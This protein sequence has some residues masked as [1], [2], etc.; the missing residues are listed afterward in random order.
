VRSNAIAYYYP[1]GL[2]TNLDGKEVVGSAA[3]LALMAYVKN[4]NMAEVW[5][6]PMGPERGV[7]STVSN[8]GYVSG[9]LGTPTT[10]V[11]LALNKGQCDSLYKVGTDINPIV[12][13][14]DAGIQ[15]NGQ[16]TSAT[17]SSALDRVNVQRL[18]MKMIRDLKRYTRI[19]VGKRNSTTNRKNLRADITAYC[20]DLVTRDAL[21]DFAVYCDT[22]N[23]TATTIDR[24]ELHAKVAFKPTKT[25]EFVYIDLVPVNT[26]DSLK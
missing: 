12:Y 25:V 11:P 15:V 1:A 5:D 8:V 13:F 18:I 7:L 4:D 17:V 22:T 19:Y 2:V 23:N 21:Y 14:D 10:F 20:A 24:N 16:K 6:A 3:G 26:G 9:V